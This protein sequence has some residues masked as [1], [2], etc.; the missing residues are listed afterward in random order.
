MAEVGEIPDRLLTTGSDRRQLANTANRQTTAFA[1]KRAS[2][3]A[4]PDDRFRAPGD[5]RLASALGHYGGP[6]LGVSKGLALPAQA[7]G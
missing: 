2:A 7:A 6:A 1:H 4:A 3:S 5:R